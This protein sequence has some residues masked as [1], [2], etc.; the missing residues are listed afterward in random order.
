MSQLLGGGNQAVSPNKLLFKG[1][2]AS[3]HL[4]EIMIKENVDLLSPNAVKTHGIDLNSDLNKPI[5]QI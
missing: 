1:Q 4:D 3:F 5:G 2:T